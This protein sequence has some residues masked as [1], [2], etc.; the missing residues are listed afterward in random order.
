MN[1]CLPHNEVE[2]EYKNA[3]L[4]SKFKDKKTVKEKFEDLKSKYPF[5]VIFFDI[6]FD[7]IIF[8]KPE[9]MKC[10]ICKIER[11]FEYL[12]KKHCNM[13]ILSWGNKKKIKKGI[14]YKKFKFKKFIDYNKEKI[15]KVFNYTKFQS[16]AI[17][18][19]FTNNFDFR[20]CFYCNKDFITKFKK[21]KDKY[22]STFQLD[23][24]YD[25]AT[26]P[27]LALSLYNFIPCCPTCNSGKV[28]GTKD[29]SHFKA[30]NDDCFDFDN[31][32]KFKLF[33][34]SSCKNLN[35][36]NKSD[37][38]IPLKENFS[39]EY[40]E[41]ISK[42][43]LNERYEAHK[44]IVYD[45]MQNAKLYPDSR[46]KELEKLTGI[47]HQQIKKDI[48]NLIDKNEDLS[49]KPF[50]KLIKDISKELGLYENIK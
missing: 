6:S 39:D 35:I 46:L 9:D 28:K 33:L 48:F 11:K 29:F 47:P 10:L 22:F 36:Q 23:H 49:K 31:K 4:S 30:P 24:F 43:K 27:Y 34:S 13:K 37:I 15:K 3:L 17:T 1:H 7:K 2:N 20:T 42:L 14:N 25:K 32:V 50:S 8:V 18:P 5:N 19:F 40:K 26:Y 21:E 38:A 45:M 16:N 12:S 44:D 41:Y